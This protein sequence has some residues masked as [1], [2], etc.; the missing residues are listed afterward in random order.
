M[1]AILVNYLVPAV[2]LIVPHPS[3]AKMSV[4]KEERRVDCDLQCAENF[5]CRE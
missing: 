5:E 2:I 1:S 3:Q 4:Q